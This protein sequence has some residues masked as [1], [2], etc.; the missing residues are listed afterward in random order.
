[1]ALHPTN[2]ELLETS[3]VSENFRA[4]ARWR[5]DE[6]SGVHLM[7]LMAMAEGRYI[8]YREAMQHNAEQ[9]STDPTSEVAAS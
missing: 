8:G 4:F 6:A 1:M 7:L 5:P 9:R 3:R 2:D